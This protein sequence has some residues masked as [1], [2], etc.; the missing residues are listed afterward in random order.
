[1]VSYHM[2]IGNLQSVL[3]AY[4]D[5]GASYAQLFFDTSPD[6]HPRAYRLLYRARRRLEDLP[7][8]GCSPRAR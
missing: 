8:G 1:M 7:T 4:G 6:R 3:G 5:D 2:G